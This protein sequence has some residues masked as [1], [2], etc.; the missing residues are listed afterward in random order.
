MDILVTIAQYVTIVSGLSE[1]KVIIARE[2]YLNSNFNNNIAVVDSLVNKTIGR[3]NDYDG[4]DD[5]EE[6]TYITYFKSQMTIDFYG[7]NALSN[8]NKFI[9]RLNSQEAHEFKRDNNIEIFHNKTI[10][11]VKEMQGK[12]TYNRFQLEIVVKYTEIFIEDVLRIDE[13]Q[14][15]VDSN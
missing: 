9:A 10:T 7:S 6:M 15:G 11:N 5:I 14:I 3:K 1:D 13:A 8:A 12:T 2:N 4:S